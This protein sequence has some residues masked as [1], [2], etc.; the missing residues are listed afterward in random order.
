MIYVL[1]KLS[2]P[3]FTLLSEHLV[4]IHRTLV[5]SLPPTCKLTEA[6]VYAKSTE[7]DSV[8]S[9]ELALY[10]SLPNSYPSLTLEEQIHCLL[11]TPC[12]SEF[13]FSAYNSYDD[14]VQSLTSSYN[15]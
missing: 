1:S 12:G 6:E 13:T 4:I 15:S 3:S 2:S 8:E 7:F 5:D 10:D 11:A 9:F 14:Y